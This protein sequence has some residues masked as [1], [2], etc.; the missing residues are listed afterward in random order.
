M[1][2]KK[3]FSKNAADL[4]LNLLIC[5]LLAT[6]LMQCGVFLSEFV[7]SSKTDG[8][9]PFEMQMLS[10]STQ[11]SY[12][13]IDKS[14][15]R[16][17]LIAV[18]SEGNA[19]AVIHSAEVMSEVYADVSACLFEALQNTAVGLSEQQWCDAVRNDAYV[20]V[21]YSGEFPYQVVFAFAAAGMESD[22]QIRRADSYIGIR[23][24]L[25]L[26]DDAGKIVQVL[27]R[28][29]D[30]AYAFAVKGETDMSLFETHLRAYPDVFYNGK[31]SVVGDET[32]FSVL[33]KISARD[34][35]VSEIGTSALRANNEH[36]ENFLRLLNY[37]PDKLRYHAEA[38][39]TYVYV[40]SHGI[41]R[42]DA[43][44]VEYSATE[45][46]G[47]SL[48][49]IVGWEATED[50]YTYLRAASRIVGRIADMDPLYIGGD[51]ELLLRS[52]SS[53]NGAITLRFSFFSD[54]I[55]IYRSN[56]DTGLTITFTE[57][58]I[59]QITFHM[60]IVRRSLS[61]HKL[62]LQSWCKEQLA[63]GMPTAMR[64]VY[65]MEEGTISI[66]AEWMAEVLGQ[67]EGVGQ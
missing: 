29:D 58:K 47:I 45:Q 46:G 13:N 16:P 26:P 38:D 61:E 19:S 40:E 35:Y 39:G 52:V 27:V 54:N 59:T 24:V 34:I 36:L 64:P 8:G 21:Q 32:E 31:M 20:Y 6:L 57:D 63:P 4:W 22:A 62:M 49:H 51:A 65:R 55:E 3:L 23:Q 1:S 2:Q 9:I 43:R 56:R 25:L 28:G 42:I 5:F 67:E 37:N 18:A 50:I 10:T 17:A 30:G 12:R 7:N 48:S 33:D 15:F 14:M 66:S 60:I 44:K 53:D 41:L 11:D